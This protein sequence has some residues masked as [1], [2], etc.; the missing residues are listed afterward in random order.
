VVAILLQG[1]FFF[2][3]AGSYF[4]SRSVFVIAAAGLLGYWILAL[5]LFLYGLSK[6]K[7]KR[8]EA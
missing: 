6:I 4:P 8:V 5:V 2:C 7:F 3:E 1:L